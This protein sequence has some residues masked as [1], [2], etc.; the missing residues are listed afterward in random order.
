MTALEGLDLTLAP[1]EVLGLLGANGAGKTTAIQILMGLLSPTSGDVQ[2]MSFSPM[3]QRYQFAHRINFSSA[4]VNLPS[5]LKV[6]EN[7]NIFSRLYNVKNGREKTHYLL[8]LFGIDH[9][10]NRVTG[11]LSSGEKTRLNLCKSLLNNPELLLLDEPTASLDPEVADRV[12]QTLQ[13]LQSK[14]KMGILYTSHNMKEVEALCHRI[15]F[16]HQGKVMAVGTA[17]EIKKQFD[18]DSMDEV[19]IKIVRG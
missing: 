18:S 13:E 15:I 11:A 17:D 5:N 12:R 3:T 10:Y 9:L 16:V 8:N 19:F 6:S 1:G 14:Q 7:M 2:V 4:Y